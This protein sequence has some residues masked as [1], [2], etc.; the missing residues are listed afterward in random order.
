MYPTKDVLHSSWEFEG[1]RKKYT[2]FIS[3]HSIV[4]VAVIV[5]NI[6]INYIS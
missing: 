3:S 5:D 4:A 2:V 6:V 1:V